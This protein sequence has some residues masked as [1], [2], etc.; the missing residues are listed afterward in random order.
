[1]FADIHLSGEGHGMH[2]LPGGSTAARRRI[3]LY[4]LLR[5]QRRHADGGAQRGR[6]Y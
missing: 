1:L 3:A 2:A 5:G 4:D 6:R